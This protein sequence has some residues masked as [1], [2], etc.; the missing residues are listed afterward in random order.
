MRT[1]WVVT[2]IAAQLVF[3]AMLAFNSEGIYRGGNTVFLST[4][5]LDPR[6]PLRGD[7]VVLRYAINRIS[8]DDYRGGAERSTLKPG[9]TVYVALGPVG[10]GLYEQQGVYSS[11]PD[12]QLYLAGRLQGEAGAVL[13]LRFGIEQLY[14]QQGEAEL[15]EA[16][17]R[18]ELGEPR[19][20]EIELAVDSR[21]RARI[22]GYR[23][24]AEKP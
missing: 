16:V 4:L 18:G 19:P 10:G 11:P 13:R 21:G 5:P 2:G 20:L 8:V 14:R 23:W 12:N 9:D 7:Y 3:L 6:D 1:K 17:Q 22:K 24:A 15:M